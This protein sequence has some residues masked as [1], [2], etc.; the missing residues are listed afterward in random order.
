MTDIEQILIN[1]YRNN[2]IGHFYILKANPA[3]ENPMTFLDE[4]ITNFLNKAIPQTSL[5]QI[6]KMNHP[7][8]LFVRSKEDKTNFNL[9]DF[10]DFFDFI[11]FK[12]FNLNKRFIIIYDA[13][14][15]TAIISNKLLV[16]LEAPPEDTVIFFL[17]PFN[18]TLLPTIQS[19]AITFTTSPKNLKPDLNNY[20]EKA[21]DIP[22][23]FINN[24]AT[25]LSEN[26]KNAIH[27]YIHKKCQE[28]KIFDLLKNHSDAQK[29]FFKLLIKI[30]QSLISD[31]EQKN[32]VLSNIQWFQQSSIFHNSFQERFFALLRS[33]FK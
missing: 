21:Q 2:T 14:K 17:N 33:T 11:K 15:L 16:T 28:T 3:I 26:L 22:F 4:W 13:H 20:F 31:Y 30:N 23:D 27:E 18:A 10:D 6:K 32:D 8:I 12:T 1:K 25:D 29:S 5:D 24:H 7:D 9:E 19:R